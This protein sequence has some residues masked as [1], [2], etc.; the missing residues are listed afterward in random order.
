M[1]PKLSKCFRCGFPE[2]EERHT[3]EF[4]REGRYVVALPV[5]ADVCARCA[6][7]YFTGDTVRWLEEVRE[8][9]RRGDLEGLTVTGELLEPAAS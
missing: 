6:E 3:E 4:L 7:K 5:D 1:D 8:R 2:I 9:V